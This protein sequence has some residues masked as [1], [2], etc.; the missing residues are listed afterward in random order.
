MSTATVKKGVMKM[1]PAEKARETRKRH[2]EA[3]RQAALEAK[4]LRAK[5]KDG[6]LSLLNDPKA[7]AREKLRATEILYELTKG[8]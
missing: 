8:R 5:M 4:M 6:C 1:T 3:Q 7:T 2:K